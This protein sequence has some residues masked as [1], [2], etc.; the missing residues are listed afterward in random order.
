MSSLLNRR[1][2]L[3]WYRR[4]SRHIIGAIAV[5]G[6]LNTGYLTLSK[7]TSTEA[8]CPT[9]G[10]E[11]VLSSSYATV[12]GLPLALFGFLAY[13]TMAVMAL[14]PLAIRPDTQ[15]Q[16]RASAEKWTWLFMFLLATAMTAFSGYLMFV[17]FSQFVAKYGVGGICYYCLFSAISATAIFV[18]TLIGHEWEDVGQALFAGLVVL[19]VT[20]VGTLGIYAP[21]NAPTTA[22]G[23]PGL[24]ITTTSSQAE[25][26]L[27]T[28]LK[29]IGAK[30][31]GAYWCPHCHDQKELFGKEAFALI[32]YVECAADGQN[33]Q[34][35]LCL[36]IQPEVQKQTGQA[37]GFPTW[38]ING[39]YYR[40]TQSLEN[41]AKE[42]GYTGP[43]NFKNGK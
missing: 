15:K 6:V 33:S 39:K 23:N 24:T 11:Q 17:M 26:G 31:F 35:D 8:A 41:L 10:C 27:A 25:I 16:L 2:T 12:F 37:F 40:G 1:R 22:N 9:Q 14:A 34:T 30:M 5:L 28:Y 7:L 38:Q 42:S 43:R 19:V 21:I 13:L 32:N 29:K 4:W 36:K 18:L 3:P 20:L